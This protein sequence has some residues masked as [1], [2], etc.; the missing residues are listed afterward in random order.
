MNLDGWRFE[1]DSSGRT[2]TAHSDPN[3]QGYSYDYFTVKL[4]KTKQWVTI[5]DPTQYYPSGDYEI[6][7]EVINWLLEVE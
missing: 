6:P 5:N 4:G 3:T 1:I 7:I 2:A